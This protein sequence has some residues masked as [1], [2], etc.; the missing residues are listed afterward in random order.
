MKMRMHHTITVIVYLMLLIFVSSNSVDQYGRSL[1]VEVM[2]W[3]HGAGVLIRC[4]APGF[5][6]C[7]QSVEIT[8]KKRGECNW[9]K[10][11]LGLNAIETKY[12]SVEDWEQSKH[13]YMYSCFFSCSN[14]VIIKKPISASCKGA[15]AVTSGNPDLNYDPCMLLGCGGSELGRL[16]PTYLDH[17]GGV[18]VRCGPTKNTL[19][20]ASDDGSNCKWGQTPYEYEHAGKLTPLQMG[21]NPVTTSCPGWGSA[22]GY[23]PCSYHK[24]DRDPSN[25]AY[26]GSVTGVFDPSRVHAY[27][28]YYVVASLFGAIAILLCYIGVIISKLSGLRSNNND[29][30]VFNK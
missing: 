26:Y 9:G 8:T 19:Q 30:F 28:P 7:Q 20:C 17:G 29:T 11:L 24:C 13:A 16:F 6:E 15:W 5:I 21:T 23:N 1:D 27:N 4:G 10:G 12:I 3:P 2:M 22:T 25:P 18:W 14:S